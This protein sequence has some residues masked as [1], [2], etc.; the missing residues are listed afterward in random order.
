MSNWPYPKIIAHRGAGTLA[1][2][3]TMAAMRYAHV[4]GFRGVEFDVMLTRDEIP[5]LMHDPD[6]GRTIAGSGNVAEHSVAQLLG[7]DA[8]S[9]FGPEFA[10]EPVPRFDQVARFCRANCIWMNVEIKPVPGYEALTGRVVAATVQHLLANL[11]HGGAARQSVAQ[12][13]LLSS[14]SVPALAAARQEAPELAY[15]L[16]VNRIPGDWR[17]QCKTL[18]VVALHVNQ[19]YLTAAD[20]A[21]VKEAG[22]GLF[23]Y[24]VNDVARAHELLGWGV[25]G[26]CT[27]RV[28][29]IGPDFG[30]VI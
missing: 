28:D 27:D 24:T 18:E 16:L 15:A 30:S 19:K 7:F 23:C 14:F 8:G 13:P 29:L 11:Q 26:F 12:L 9:W 6:F 17:Q 10:G 25:D 3:N 5:V 22:Y 21:A 2:E 1:P 20:A 4:H